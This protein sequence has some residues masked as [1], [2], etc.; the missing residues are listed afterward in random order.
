M[1][2]SNSGIS[3]LALQAIDVNK[4]Y[5]RSPSTYY[6]LRSVNMNVPQGIMWVFVT[7]RNVI[8]NSFPLHCY[9]II[10]RASLWNLTRI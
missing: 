3:P 1:D 7:P 8:I 10:D 6:V 5:G 2:E 4:Y 9:L